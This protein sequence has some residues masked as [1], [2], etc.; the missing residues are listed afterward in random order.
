M[1][2]LACLRLRW[3]S[4][5]MGCLTHRYRRQASSHRG[6]E[7]FVGLVDDPAQEP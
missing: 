5:R 4:R 1:W 6:F 7:V 3:V 2:E